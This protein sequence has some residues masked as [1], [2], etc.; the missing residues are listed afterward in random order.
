[1]AK[2]SSRGGRFRGAYSERW[3]APSRGR[4]MADGLDRG[5]QGTG[6]FNGL[7]ALWGTLAI[8]LTTARLVGFLRA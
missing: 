2:Q 3:R 6:W 4:L 7:P 8:S 1:M 5:R